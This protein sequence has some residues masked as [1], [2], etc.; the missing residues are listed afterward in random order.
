M[1]TGTERTTRIHT[2][3]RGRPAAAALLALLLAA[4]ALPVHGKDVL[5]LRLQQV[6]ARQEGE[7]AVVVRTYAS[8]PVGQGQLCVQTRPRTNTATAAVAAALAGFVAAPVAPPPGPFAALAD[9]RVFSDAGDAASSATLEQADGAAMMVVRFD[10][11]SAT[12]NAT[13]GPLAV[14]HLRLDPSVAPGERFDLVLDAENTFLFDAAGR[15]VEIAPRD[16]L[17]VIR[18]PDDAVRVEVDGDKPEPGRVANVAVET[19]EPL[20][21]ARGHA[22]LRYDPSLLAGPPVVRM[23]GRHGTTT[24]TVDASV[25]GLLGVSF[26]SPDGSLGRVPGQWIQIDLPTSAAV[27]PGTL[28]E[29]SLD[30][31][32]TFLE[33]RDG[34]AVELDLKPGWLEFRAPKEKGK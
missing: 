30:P 20:H 7:V 31:A 19:A 32:L 10:A 17:L 15:P 13:E 16:G 2:A 34:E 5:R 29:I 21:L 23:D 3:R 11:P 1:T 6:D 25:P 14:F 33:D 22:A 28:S 26:E 27:A 18:A 24:F 4:A 12:V 8:R 9:H